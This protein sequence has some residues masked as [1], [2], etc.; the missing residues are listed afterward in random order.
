MRKALGI[1]AALALMLALAAGVNAATGA[2]SVQSFA[3]VSSDGSC[4]V[5]MVLTIH[6]EQPG[7]KLYFPIPKAATG[8]R[9]NGSRVNAAKSGDSKRIN[10]SRIAGKVSG[11]VTVNIQ[12][13]LRDVIHTNEAGVLELQVPLLSGFE[14]AV[15]SLSFS[16]TLPG[17]F[18]TLPGFTS[19][20]H[21]AGIEEHLTYTVD[22]ATVSGSSQKTMKDHETLTMIMAVSEEMFPQSIVEK[23][24]VGTAAVGVGICAGLALVYWLIFLWNL[25]VWPTRN[26]QPPQGI[27]AGRLGCA[28]A[29]Q[30]V[31]FTM[32][33]FHWAQLGY[34]SIRVDRKNRV[35]LQKRMDMGN[36]CT[37]AEQ[38]CFQR[39]FGRGALVDTASYRYA[40]LVLQMEKTPAGV[41][42]LVKK[43]TGNSRV[44]RVLASG[45]GL[46]GGAGI[47]LAMGSGGLLQGFLVVVLAVAGTL[48][49]WL[50][51]SWSRG[52]WLRG[53]K[54]L[55]QALAVCGV[56]LLFALI[57]G[58]F[59]FGLWT[60]VGLLTAGV[61]LGWGGRRTHLGRQVLTQIMGLRRYLRTVDKT[62]LRQM[63]E[64][65][66]DCFFRLAPYAMALGVDKAFAAR[67]GNQKLSDCPYLQWGG[68]ARM[69]A[70]QWCQVMN[71]AADAME[72]RADRLPLEKLISLMQRIR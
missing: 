28:M 19:G 29:L 67:F 7:Q 27:G 2:T 21:Q 62:Q 14:Y 71:L 68:D 57:V 45:M 23:Q 37:E 72:R 55:L 41:Q 22:G 61:L 63:Q 34:L 32:T 38:R 4:Q 1:L 54:K 49:G 24:S 44:F 48:G 12:Y 8:V 31:D 51:Q 65:D 26:A 15:E 11:D 18:D 36:E 10:L 9:V 47:G 30:G 43:H 64:A 59:V 35:L 50:I 17:A 52:L 39:L 33:V 56:W 13:S 42:E 40:Q 6:N 3:T 70:L 5:S 58:E 16:V 69:S 53:R 25:P 20:Y 46:F 60:V 66:P